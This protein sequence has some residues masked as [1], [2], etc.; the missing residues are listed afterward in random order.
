MPLKTR[1]ERG[2]GVNGDR[3]KA[4][5]RSHDHVANSTEE[6]CWHDPLDIAYQ[7]GSQIDLRDHAG[8][9]SVA[10][11]ATMTFMKIIGLLRRR[12]PFL[13]QADDGPGHTSPRWGQP[14]DSAQD[15]GFLIRYWGQM[16]SDEL[17]NLKAFLTAPDGFSLEVHDGASSASPGTFLRCNLLVYG[18]PNLRKMTGLRR[19]APDNVCCKPTSDK[20]LGRWCTF[21]TWSLLGVVVHHTVLELPNESA[22]GLGWHAHPISV[23]SRFG[24]SRM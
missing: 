6:S 15:L 19:F 5:L 8:R 20:H 17:R 4:L 9:L 18:G 13:A 23:E 21:A 12:S 16:K 22:T 14:N 24:C 7:A 1:W 11:P 10:V 3:E 2:R